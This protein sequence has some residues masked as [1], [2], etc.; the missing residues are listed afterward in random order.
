MDEMTRTDELLEFFKAM[1]DASRLK[2]IGVLAQQPSTVEQLAAMLELQPSTIS[3]HLSYLSHV[4]LVSA[5][6]EGYY[7]IYRFEDAALEAM[8]RRLL[9][10]DTLPA[11]AA[12]VDMDAYDR[13]VL[14]DFSLPDG[15]L[16]SL[17]AQRKKLE[18]VLR[19]AVKLFE[20]DVR[21]PEKQVNQILSQLH[22]D[23]ATLRRELIEYKMMARDHGIY[24][25]VQA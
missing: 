8:A 2:I 4:G 13:K 11:V 20:F 7:N 17:P 19:H 1:A 12:N 25:R 15:R 5:R 3:R 22:E 10:R 6:A 9:A 16:K 23:Y 21:Y 24:W 14:R 18:A